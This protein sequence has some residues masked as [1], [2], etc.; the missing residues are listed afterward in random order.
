MA[1]LNQFVTRGPH[2]VNYWTSSTMT[3][4]ECFNSQ[5]GPGQAFFNVTCDTSRWLRTE[6]SVQTLEW[7]LDTVRSSRGSSPPSRAIYDGYIPWN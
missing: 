5:H 2:F 3:K 1:N 7:G 4:S 6:E